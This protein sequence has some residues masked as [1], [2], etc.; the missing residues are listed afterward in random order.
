MNIS[1]IG[2]GYVGL[3]AGACFAKMGN[4]VVCVDR[5]EE[6]IAMLARGVIPIYEP[7]LEELVR[8]N[9]DGGS[10]SFTSDLP[11]AV[12]RTDICFIAVGTPMDENGEADLRHVLDVAR[13]IGR[14]MD[15]PMT[16]VD[17]STVPVG[18]AD[19]VRGAIAG[20]LRERG[21][22]IPFDVVSNPEFLKE[23][24]A[25]ADFLKPD[26]VVV[27]VDGERAL[28]VMRELYAPFTRNHDNLLVMDTRSAEMTKYAANAMLA[29][30]ISFINEIANLCERVGADVNNVRL[31]IGSDRR[32]GYAFL[33][34]GCG[35]GGSCFPKDVRALICTSR[36]HGYDA[37][38]IAAVEAVNNRQKTLIADK[39]IRRF[40]ERLDGRTFA[41]WGLAFK[42]G[43]DDMRESPALSVI[44]R[45]TG[46]GASVRAYDPKAMQHA[47]ERYFAGNRAITYCNDKYEALLGADALLLLT[48]WPEFRQPDFKRMKESL[49]E[50]VLFDGR[51]QYNA[52]KLR[53]L[54]FEYH[55]CG[56][57]AANN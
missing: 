53:E 7:G 41:V 27:G 55:S 46:L 16:V 20:A 30:R 57:K 36:E 52:A 1:I 22:D 56:M 28:S 31:G 42:P 17:K 44:T 49:L 15:K 35:Y 9:M 18:T 5:D 33:Y 50:P 37:E 6:K 45:L 26:R 38:L 14:S 8:E 3:V 34:P 32:I 54:G 39:A 24:A 25:L 43:T 29:C 13:D 40:G 23:G 12:R 47:R 2:T 48:E 21:L 10:L 51:N 4:S 11:D 19:R